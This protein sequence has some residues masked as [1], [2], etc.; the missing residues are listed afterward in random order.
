[1]ELLADL[2]E[3]SLSYHFSRQTF[4]LWKTLKGHMVKSTM[5][6]NS[7]GSIHQDDPMRL[8]LPHGLKERGTWLNPP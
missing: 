2:H 5:A 4:I 3:A 6:P 7:P 8:N 1:V